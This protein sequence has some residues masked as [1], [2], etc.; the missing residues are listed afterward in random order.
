M[1]S[2]TVTLV[3]ASLE[4]C[5]PAR[6]RQLFTER[7]ATLQGSTDVLVLPEM[8]TTGFQMQP[9]QVAES[10]DGPTVEWLRTHARH[11][12]AVVTGSVA[13]ASDGRFV[14]RLY[15]AQPDGV[16][17]SYDKRHLFRVAGEHDQYDPG[18]QRVVF[19][20]RGWRISPFICYD[21]RFPVWSRRTITNDFDLMLYVANWPSSRRKAWQTLLVARAIENL[22]YCV[23]VNRV[24]TDGSGLHYAGD[25]MASNFTG[26]LLA[27]AGE[28]EWMASV[29]LDGEALVRFR[30]QFP[31]HLDA[32]EFALQP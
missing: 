16:V 12:D 10:S 17:Y 23:G 1:Q 8:F 7:F 26:D 32:D 28:G 13:V 3:Q 31:A 5:N 9:E 6:N 4:W 22:S 25:S 11:L 2:L 15:W 14:N 21:L 19:T 20:W 29:E 24:G 27:E 30:E 18:M